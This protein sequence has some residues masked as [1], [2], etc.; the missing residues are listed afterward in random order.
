MRY[1]KN[2]S[3]VSAWLGLR[4]KEPGLKL[5]RCDILLCYAH[6]KTAAIAAE[7]RLP[8]ML[9]NVSPLFRNTRTSYPLCNLSLP[10]Q[11]QYTTYS[12]PLLANLS[13]S[14]QLVNRFEITL[15]LGVPLKKP[16]NRG[17]VNPSFT[18]CVSHMM[19]NSP[20]DLCFP[21]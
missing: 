1:I 20:M 14:A 7:T 13:S 9:A 21:W 15:I 10:R 11:V 5:D 18:W 2:V 16:C 19:G 3:C 4:V 17:I 12:T 8:S 6:H